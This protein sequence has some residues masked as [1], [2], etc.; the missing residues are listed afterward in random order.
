LRASSLSSTKVIDLLNGY[1][2]P[3]SLRNQDFADEG[4]ASADEKSEKA[5]IYRDALKAG[6]HAGTVCVYLVS[7]DG[8][9]MA[10]APAN[11]DLVY[12]PDRLAELMLLVVRQLNVVK[13]EPS[14]GPKRYSPAPRMSDETLVLHIVARYL[15]RK[16]DV[17]VPYD[18]KAVLGTKN[19]RNWADL[20]SQEWVA[21][22]RPEWMSLLPRGEV[23]LDST[24]KP[25]EDVTAKL[26][27]HIYP[28][29]E[30][31]DLKT[32]RVEKLVIQARVESI[33]RGVARARLDGRMRMKHPF[34][35]QDDNNFVEADLVGY[36]RFNTDK[37]V[38]KSLRL[39]TDHGRYG[40]NVN[41]TQLFGAAARSATEPIPRVGP[42]ANEFSDTRMTSPRARDWIPTGMTR[43]CR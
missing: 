10:V 23:R 22:S 28:P 14:A 34:Y 8:W 4:A 3:V 7:P 37:L 20:P 16:G 33:E 12:D 26:L 42:L 18:A 2:V 11:E 21:L 19:G 30:N 29:T 13:A 41:G 25:S 15:E 36:V 6:M 27:R 5:R 38:V 32:N 24:W 31:T 9:P 35:H 1:F 43:E 40:G 17:C 39:V